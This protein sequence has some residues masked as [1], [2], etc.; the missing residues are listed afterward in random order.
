MSELMGKV[1]VIEF[2]ESLTIVDGLPHHKHRGQREFVVVNNLRKVFQLATIDLLV[3]PRQVVT[4][5]NGRILRVFLQEFAL[6]IVDNR[7]S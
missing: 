2:R 7:S 5:G 1:F 6:H 3:W 4:G